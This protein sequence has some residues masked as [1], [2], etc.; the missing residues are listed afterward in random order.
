MDYRKL[1]EE[2]IHEKAVWVHRLAREV[3]PDLPLKQDAV[4]SDTMLCTGYDLYQKDYE[5]LAEFI[6][7]VH[8]G[9]Y[10]DDRQDHIAAMMV[11]VD[12][13][14]PCSY[15]NLMR[16]ANEE[17]PEWFRCMFDGG[18]RAVM[19]EYCRAARDAKV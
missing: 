5:R 11:F 2:K 4:I 13:H 18:V 6:R 10:R 15:T 9:R 1:S 14:S 3:A 12:E 8:E 17:R 19:K 7:A 16:Y